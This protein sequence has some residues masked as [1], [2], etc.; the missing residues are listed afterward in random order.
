MLHECGH[1]NSSRYSFLNTL[2]GHYASLFCFMPYFPWKYI[3][4]EHHAWTGNVERDPTL[5]AIRNYRADQRFKNGLIHLAWRTWVP[6]LAFIQ[7]LVLWNY[8][9]ALLRL[10]RLRGGRLVRGLLSV[11]LLPSVYFTLYCYWPDLFCLG[12]FW[13]ALLLYL[14][15]VELINLPHHVGLFHPPGSEAGK[16]PLWEHGRVTRSCYYPTGV[17]ELLLLNF[18]FHV[19]HHLFPTLPWFRLRQARCLVR[20]AL[21]DEYQESVGIAWTLENR[22]KDALQVFF[23][24]AADR[25]ASTPM[26]VETPCG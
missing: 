21:G 11:L 8:P 20:E 16:L 23:A 15:L 25:A 4:T 9:L 12:S 10:G 17:S 14:V 24:P 18:N 26:K 13:P 1:E 2:T 3:H 5:A 6:L 19:E 22:R 7:H